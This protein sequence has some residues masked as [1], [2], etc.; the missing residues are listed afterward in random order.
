ML[1]SA[2]IQRLRLPGGRPFQLLIT[3][4]A[5]STCGDWLYNVALLAIVYERTGSAT[6]VSLTTAARVL[7]IVAL[8]PL[9]GVMADRYDR[10][11]L[12]IGA[13]VIR[14]GLMVVLGIVAAA[15]LPVLLAPVLAAAATAVGSVYP[16]CVAASTARF[17]ASEELQRAN[18]LRAA[19][20][21]ASIVVGPALG[22]LVMVLA[23]PSAAILLNGVTFIASA[24]AVGAIGGNEKFAPPERA[25]AAQMPSVLAEIRTGARALRGAPT[26]IRLVA[27]DVLGSAVYGMLTVTLVLVSR[28]V[29]A[30]SGGYGLLLGGFGVGGLIGAS[31]IARLD[32]PSRWRRTLAIAMVLVGLPLAALGVVPSLP[33]A[34]ALAVL[35][36]GGM[37]VGEV[38]GETA[39]PRMLDDEVLA[40]AYGLVFPISIAGIVAGSLIAGPLVSLLGLTGTMAVGGAAVLAIGGLLVSR[41]LEVS[42]GAPAAAPATA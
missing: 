11:R 5:V 22:A 37:I 12:M 15:G 16:S 30:G 33:G 34:I 14:A 28:K 35:G 38:L 31:V 42:A 8:G 18:A 40:R 1:A 36:G 7:P 29:G 17:V 3:S 6:W 24:L 9:G 10:R 41:P 25:A 13:D 32:A 23:G 20:G 26:A 21:Q 4:L 27:A 19:V 2:L 39:L